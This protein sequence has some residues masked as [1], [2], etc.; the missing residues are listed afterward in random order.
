V[1][2]LIFHAIG[3]IGRRIAMLPVVEYAQVSA[4]VCKRKRIRCSR[5]M[6]P[7]S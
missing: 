7:P 5:L 1:Q 4:Q 6:V 2:L 3:P